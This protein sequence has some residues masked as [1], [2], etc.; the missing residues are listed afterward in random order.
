MHILKSFLEIVWP[1]KKVKTFF[2]RWTLKFLFIFLFW[3]TLESVA[4]DK[5]INSADTVKINGLLQQLKENYSESPEN[6]KAIY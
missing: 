3:V 6:G 5:G 4:Q 2:M 1:F